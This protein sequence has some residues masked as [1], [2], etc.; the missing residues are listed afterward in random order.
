MMLLEGLIIIK[1][2]AS[3]Y[4]PTVKTAVPSPLLSLTSVFGMGTGVSS[5]LLTQPKNLYI[6][7]MSLTTKKS[8]QINLH[9]SNL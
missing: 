4:S 5:T 6:I 7:I 3:C 1:K 9:I 8:S 2:A